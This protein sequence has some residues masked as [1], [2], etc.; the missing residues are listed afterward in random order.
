MACR[1]YKNILSA[2]ID[3]ELKPLTRMRVESHLRGC[4]RCRRQLRQTRRATE[5]V[6]GL[7]REETPAFAVRRARSISVGGRARGWERLRGGLVSRP[8]TLP[9][10]PVLLAGLA[11]V[12]VLVISRTFDT[13]LAPQMGQAPAP[14]DAPSAPSADDAPAGL[15]GTLSAARLSDAQKT[16]IARRVM[17]SRAQQNAQGAPAQQPAL[18]EPTA[19]EAPD[20]RLA[21]R[22]AQPQPATQQPT[23]QPEAARVAQAT[24]EADQELDPLLPADSGAPVAAPREESRIATA[25]QPAGGLLIQPG[26]APPEVVAESQQ[27]SA[28]SRGTESPAASEPAASPDLLDLLDLGETYREVLVLAQGDGG[29]LDAAFHR[30]ETDA[31]GRLSRFDA[32]DPAGTMEGESVGSARERLAAPEPDPDTGIAPP[33]ALYR[34]APVLGQR[35]R[36]RRDLGPLSPALL[37]VHILADGTVGTLAL[38]SGSGLRW[39]DRAVVEAVRDWEFRPAERHQQA[40]P[41]SIEL[42]VEFEL[43]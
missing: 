11:F 30:A 33:L 34:P 29:N 31:S 18:D 38:I 21:S 36:G 9:L 10:K 16:E 27:A 40:I 7:E 13:T 43:E 14:Q 3:D 32:G 35:A 15:P 6:R 12:M 20:T 41:V 1:E 23:A 37:R 19:G 5:M 24:P 2:F 17:E 25:R 26:A 28:D 42:L 4:G 39:L 22:D 8:Q